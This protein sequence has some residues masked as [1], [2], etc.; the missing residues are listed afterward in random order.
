MKFSEFVGNDRIVRYFQ[1]AISEDHLGHAYLFSG[2]DGIGKRTL[3][4]LIC[5]A[6]LCKNPT[7]D[8]P[9]DVCPSCHKFDS[10]NHSDFHS[11]A[12]EG[13]YFKIELV[14]QII[15]L[16]SLKPVESK[17]KTFVLE[18]VDFMREEASNALL[19]VLEEPP[20]QTI[21]FLLAQTPD[22]LLP[23]IH[24]R[25]QNFPLQPAD[26]EQIAKWL[27]NKM[28]YSKEEASHVAP[29]SHGSLGRA[30]TLNA[31]Q[32]LAVRDKVLAI[33]RVAILPGSYY[34]LLDAIKAVTVERSE[35]A[36][37]LLILE[38]LVRDLIVLKTS[39]DAHLIHADERE[40]L[41]QLSS[42]L[43][44][45]ALQKFYEELLE[46]REAV[47]KINANVSLA[48]QGLFLPLRATR[49]SP[50]SK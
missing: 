9:C 22:V 24:S 29:F 18:N 33:L 35:M 31:E 38:E 21:F 27:M 1:K 26:P 40:K 41:K 23:T 34:Q 48:L 15:H 14:R 32:Y 44:D 39:D 19:K 13:L 2:P 6:L 42:A 47:L 10:G 30:L 16:A 5:K 7:P 36:E 25:C 28:E 8:G 50:P 3:S 20:G 49:P 17:W 37:R 11:F 4:H 46:V 45:S 43:S 12:P